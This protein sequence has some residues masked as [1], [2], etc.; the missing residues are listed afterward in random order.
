MRF[1]VVI[2]VESMGERLMTANVDKELRMFR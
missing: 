2:N 1:E